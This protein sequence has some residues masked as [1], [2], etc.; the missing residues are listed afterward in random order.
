MAST[1]WLLT[2]PWFATMTYGG[3]TPTLVSWQASNAHLAHPS[4]TQ[5]TN[6]C[7]GFVAVLL[8]A[9]GV[10][11]LFWG[12][13]VTNRGTLYLEQGTERRWHELLE[14][15]SELYG[16][17]SGTWQAVELAR[18]CDELHA[19]SQLLETQE[20]SR[21][22]LGSDI[23]PSD[24][25]RCWMCRSRHRR[26]TGSCIMSMRSMRGGGSWWR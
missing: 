21:A 7:V 18:V 6:S 22:Y 20:P 10:P 3:S 26:R 17:E 4:D 23:L 8:Y 13:L 1:S 12:V 2:T 5:M 19:C 15:V 14:R 24:T 25:Q 16:A 9:V 11:L